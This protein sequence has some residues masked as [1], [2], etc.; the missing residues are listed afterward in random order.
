MILVNHACWCCSRY[1]FFNASVKVF[2]ARGLTNYSPVITAHQTSQPK[3]Q[4]RRFRVPQICLT[5]NLRVEIFTN[6]HPVLRIGFYVTVISLRYCLHSF[7]LYHNFS[8]KSSLCISLEAQ[9]TQNNIVTKLT[10]KWKLNKNV[11]NRSNNNNNNISRSTNIFT[12]RYIIFSWRLHALF[13]K[14]LKIQR[15]ILHDVVD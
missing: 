8:F 15:K 9:G 11:T 1:I 6:R 2:R 3:R 5:W 10:E 12:F 13:N 7:L 4:R 14:A